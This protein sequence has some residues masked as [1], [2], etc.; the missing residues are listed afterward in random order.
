LLFN[1]QIVELISRRMFFAFASKTPIAAILM[2]VEL[3]GVTIGSRGRRSNHRLSGDR[4]SQYLSRS[5]TCVRQIDVDAHSARYVM[6]A[7]TAQCP[8]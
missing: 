1:G 4:P 2:G 3:F 5:A 6:N 8:C 7:D